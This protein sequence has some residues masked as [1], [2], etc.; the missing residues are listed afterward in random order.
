MEALSDE[1]L[2]ECY[3]SMDDKIQSLVRRYTWDFVPM[4][5]VADNNVLPGTWYF[6][7]KQDLV[8]LSVN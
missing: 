6:E 3:K 8:G 7:C 1:H 5:S 4:K 2:G